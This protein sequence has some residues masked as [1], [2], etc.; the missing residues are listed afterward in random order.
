MEIYP[1]HKLIEVQER[2]THS[3]YSHIN[4]LTSP[5]FNLLG[6][7]ITFYRL[8]LKRGVL[9][10]A[11]PSQ[12]SQANTLIFPTFIF[13]FLSFLPTI[14]LQ[15]TD[16]NPREG[17]IPRKLMRGNSKLLRLSKSYKSQ[18]KR[19]TKFPFSYELIYTNDRHFSRLMQDTQSTTHKA[20]RGRLLPASIS[21]SYFT[22]R[23]IP[24]LYRYKFKRGALSLANFKRGISRLL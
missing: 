3:Q 21:S 7:T 2:A 13:Y 9:S 16:T 17:I 23:T 12:R 5:T 1:N 14:F 20:K 18:V 15:S 24:S 8:N 19:G 6:N 11:T 4:L 10:V 22:L